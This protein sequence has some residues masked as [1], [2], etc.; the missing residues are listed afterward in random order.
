MDR[1]GA[2]ARL[3][4]RAGRGG[5]SRWRPR[6][7]YLFCSIDTR[8]IAAVDG[9]QVPGRQR[10][11]SLSV[12]G[13]GGRRRRGGGRGWE[14]RIEKGGGRL[15]WLVL[16]QKARARRE[17]KMEKP[18]GG[19]FAAMSPTSIGRRRHATMEVTSGRERIPRGRR[20]GWGE[21]GGRGEKAQAGALALALALTLALALALAEERGLAG[22]KTRQGSSEQATQP[23]RWREAGER[24]CRRRRAGDMGGS[25][26]A[27]SSVGVGR[28]RTRGRQTQREKRRRRTDRQ[29]GAP[30]NGL[31]ARNQGKKKRQTSAVLRILA[32]IRRDCRTAGTYLEAGPP[33][34]PSTAGFAGANWRACRGRRPAHWSAPRRWQQVRAFAAAAA[35]CHSQ[36]PAPSV[37]SAAEE[38][39]SSISPRRPMAGPNCK[40]LQDGRLFWLVFCLLWCWCWCWC[41]C[42][43]SSTPLL[44]KGAPL[45]PMAC[46][47]GAKGTATFDV[48]LGVLEA[49]LSAPLPRLSLS[50]VL[51]ALLSILSCFFY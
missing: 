45:R 31:D 11:R 36:S 41:W 16:K 32:L 9:R 1:R 10:R 8:T 44:R 34:K 51:I 7:Y 26:A 19:A 50:P 48:P 13:K 28:R 4:G 12:P 6:L 3:R 49:S 43:C 25:V 37:D 42:C 17:T 15:K 46:A 22:G 33:Q 18:S 39:F 30:D 14:A 29:A 38:F 5:G 27:A 20:P 21:A 2:T 23:R 47:E 24:Q 40:R 35:R